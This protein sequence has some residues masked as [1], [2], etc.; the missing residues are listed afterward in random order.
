MEASAGANTAG[1]GY[2]RK[3]RLLAGALRRAGPGLLA[4]HAGLGRNLYRQQ[5]GELQGVITVANSDG[6]P[7][8]TIVLTGSFAASSN[9]TV[10]T[11]PIT[12]DTQGFTLFGPA[13]GGTL[14]TGAGAVRTLVGTFRGTPAGLQERR[15]KSGTGLR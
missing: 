10:P 13:N 12:I 3:G 1:I 4:L 7:S 8:S 14:F 2:I 15:C 11:K 9:L 6:D 5:S